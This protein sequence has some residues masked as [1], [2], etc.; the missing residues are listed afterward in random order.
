[1]DSSAS[2]SGPAE[3]RR[4]LTAV[5]WTSLLTDV[6]SEMVLNLLPLY[7][8]AV[9]GVKTSVIGLI[10][11]LAESVSSLVKV[12]S[13]VWSDRL[14]RRKPLAVAG[15]GL[16]A[17]SK[18]LFLVAQSWPAVAALRWADRVGKG[19]RTAPRDALLADSVGADRRGFAFGLH[20]AADTLGAAI[21]I[22]GALLVV[23]LMQGESP[24]L[25]APTFQ[26]LVWASLL[27][28][29]AA[30]AVLALGAREV[31]PANPPESS[32]RAP[33][34]FSRAAW[35]GLGRPFL[36][37]LA[38]AALFDLGNSSDAFLVLRASERGAS[39]MAVLAMLLAFNLVYAISALPAGR[40]SDRFG[41][42]GLLVT[43]WGLY[44]LLYLG[45]ARAQS[46]SEIFVLFAAYGLYYGL[47]MGS[48]KALIADLVPAAQR[49][50]AFGLFAAVLA[51]CDLP[52]SVAAGVLWEGAWGFEGF[53]PAAPFYF[54][55]AMA[56]LASLLLLMSPLGR[57]PTPG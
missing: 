37:F 51:L 14:G 23:F 42:R 29:F 40:L 8:S 6:S 53:G 31:A 45:F 27:P 24:T 25:T 9:L 34:F 2:H 33:R 17:V 15:Y 52:A 35:S 12:F 18:A 32:R 5:A 19:L 39:V 26:A 3:G 11:G 46:Q 16:S 49:G 4:N 28:A 44:A 55:A 38:I 54:G 48:A 13:G 22:G 7:L 30:V 36:I 41:R 50:T 20:R 21:G 57:P 43:G 1:M 10:E 56:A 47:T